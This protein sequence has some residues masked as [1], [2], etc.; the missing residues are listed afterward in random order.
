MS[1][2]AAGELQLEVQDI[3]IILGLLTPRSTGAKSDTGGRSAQAA[4]AARVVSLVR[5][6]HE[7]LQ[8][9]HAAREATATAILALAADA[10]SEA[11]TWGEK[12]FADIEATIGAWR[13]SGVASQTTAPADSDGIAT[14]IHDLAVDG[15][16]GG[17]IARAVTLFATLLHLKKQEADALSGLALCGVRLGQFSEA[18][19][20]ANECLNLP[21]KH[22]RAYC[23]AGFCE[24]ERGNRKAAQSLL[25]LGA[26]IARKRPEFAEDLRAAQRVLLLLHFS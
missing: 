22:P 7:E 2:L 1:A 11:D 6:A 26:R 3:E 13:G 15:F 20:L 23:I 14:F 12:A 9:R 25:A 4:D 19:T 17:H 16:K 24:L 18:L 8:R 21:V 5:S 10:L